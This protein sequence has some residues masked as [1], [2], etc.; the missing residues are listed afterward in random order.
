MPTKGQNG[1]DFLIAVNIGDSVTPVYSVVGGQ[2]D[3]TI[4]RAS[5]AID[6][7]SKDSPHAEFIP[8]RRSKTIQFDSLLVP[9]AAAYGKLAEAQENGELVRVRRK[10]FGQE[11]LEADG[12]VTSLSE[13]FPDQGAATVS[14]SIQISGTFTPV[15]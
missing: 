8:G 12:V 9:N 10:D 1:S 14:A 11:V 6:V 2:R 5:D 13:G 3:M 4:D 7:S 15:A